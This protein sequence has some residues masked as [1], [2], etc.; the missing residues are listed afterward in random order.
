MEQ[1]MTLDLREI[2]Q[3]IRKGLWIILLITIISVGASGVVSYYVLTPSYEASTT[4]II[5][6]SPKQAEEYGY[7]YSDVLM[8]QQLAK[9]YG[10]IAESR[11]VAEKAA[12]KLGQDV[13]T[14]DVLSK[15]SITPRVDTQI[16]EITATSISGEDAKNTANALS[17]AFIDEAMRIFPTGN[18]QIMDRATYPQNPVSP[19]PMLNMAIAFFLGLMVSLGII[20]LKEYLDNTIKTENDINKLLGITVIGIIPQY[21]KK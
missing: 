3:I 9:T 21:R 14:E 20:F 1:E 10:A 15:V 11:S 8:Y 18:V 4:I 12:R 5:G 6:N 19:R 13:R 2:F 17:E 16:M 7:E